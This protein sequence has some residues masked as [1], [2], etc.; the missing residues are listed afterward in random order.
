MPIVHLS[1]ALH[2][3]AQPGIDLHTVPALSHGGASSYV[4]ATVPMPILRPS[5]QRE[6]QHAITHEDTLSD[7]SST[8]RAR[9]KKWHTSRV[10]ASGGRI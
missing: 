1:L 3:I 6:A 10:N 4:V 2:P 7:A 5:I 8:H 9:R